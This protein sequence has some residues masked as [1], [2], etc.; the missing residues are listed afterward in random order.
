MK[1]AYIALIAAVSA[2]EDAAAVTDD[3]VGTIGLGGKCLSTGDGTGCI[4]EHRCAVI[5]A[6][7]DACAA[8]ALKKVTDAAAAA[9]DDAGDDDA[10][11]DDAGDCDEACV[12]KA[13]DA[14]TAAQ[15]VIDDAEAAE[16]ARY[17]ALT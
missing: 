8:A 7:D 14:A 13:A 4:A 17:A 12:K 15:K 10:G 1:F 16:T 2:A 9:T 11:D 5:P 3:A 6:C